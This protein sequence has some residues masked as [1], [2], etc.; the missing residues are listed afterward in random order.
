MGVHAGKSTVGENNKCVNLIFHTQKHFVYPKKNHVAV[1][2]VT[3]HTW[4][5]QTQTFF[6]F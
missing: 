1:C 2:M 6:L 5:T 4:L 3:S